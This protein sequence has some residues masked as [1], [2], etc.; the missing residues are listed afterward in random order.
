MGNILSP[1]QMLTPAFTNFQQNKVTCVW[2][3]SS[4]CAHH[5]LRWS[6]YRQETWIHCAKPAALLHFP[7]SPWRLCSSCSQSEVRNKTCAQSEMREGVASLRVNFP[8]LWKAAVAWELTL[9]PPGRD[10]EWGRTGGRHWRKEL[11]F[12]RT[13]VSLFTAAH[14]ILPTTSGLV[15]KRADSGGSFQA[16]SYDSCMAVGKSLCLSFLICRLVI[17]EDINGTSA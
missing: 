5:L 15:V 4:A 17:K 2:L 8:S 7:L 6:L 16:A 13:T 11:V 14:L 9:F 12:T 1:S 3:S 10:A